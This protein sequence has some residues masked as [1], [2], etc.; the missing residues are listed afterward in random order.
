MAD[1]TFYVG[2]GLGKLKLNEIQQQKLGR[3]NSWQYVNSEPYSTD[4]FDLR[5]L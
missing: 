2:R 1:L 4:I 3:Q 5:Q